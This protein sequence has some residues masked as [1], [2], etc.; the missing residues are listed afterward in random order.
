MEQKNK[1]IPHYIQIRTYIVDQIN[2][3]IL[4]AGDRLPSENKL[5]LQFDVSR[6]TVK[7]ALDSLVKDGR[8][9]RVQGKGTFVATEGGEPS[10]Y[11]KE[12]TTSLPLISYITPCIDNS[13]TARLLQGIEQELSEAGYKLIFSN[14]N[15]SQEKEKQLIKEALSL[16]VKGFLVFPVDGEMYNEEIVQLTMSDFP[17]VLIDREL[18]GLSTHCVCSDHAGGAYLATNHLIKQGHT[19]IAYLSFSAPFTASTEDRL[20]GYEKALADADLPILHH[21]RLQVRNS[22]EIV[23]FLDSHPEVTA[24]FAE[25]SGVGQS[26][27]EAA[28]IKDI[29]IPERLSIVFFDDFDFPNLTTPPPTVVLQQEETI[30]R[31]SAQLLLSLIK[32]PNKLKQK[33]MLPTT[34]IIRESTGAPYKI[35]T[36]IDLSGSK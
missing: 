17:I 35:P 26:V 23:A 28:R 20:A 10:L 3:Q 33:K 8:I 12:T 16:G 13:F 1:R 21:H 22:E 29:S 36:V 27:F 31:E 34:L 6:I 30:G 2:N 19:S 7:N 18:S 4:R 32:S 5:A 11:K 24:I 9:Y 15:G 25:N 14:S